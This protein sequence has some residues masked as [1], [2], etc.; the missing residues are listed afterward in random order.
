MWYN[1]Q[2]NFHSLHGSQNEKRQHQTGSLKRPGVSFTDLPALLDSLLPR[3]TDINSFVIL[4]GDCEAGKSVLQPHIKIKIL[5]RQHCL[6]PQLCLAMM[7]IWLSHI[8]IWIMLLTLEAPVFLGN[9]TQKFFT[10]DFLWI[11]SP[12]PLSITLGSSEIF[13]KF[14]EIFKTLQILYDK[15]FTVVNDTGDKLLAV[16]LWAAI[17]YMQRCWHQVFKPCPWISSIS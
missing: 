9:L 16:L 8:K 5:T 13:T 14:V 11:C 12:R 1:V 4:L 2:F 6:K 17:K 15:L 7:K 3:Y 10:P